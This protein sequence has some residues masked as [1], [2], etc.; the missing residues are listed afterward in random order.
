MKVLIIE[1]DPSMRDGLKSILEKESF[2]VECADNGNQGSYLA[3]SKNYDLILLDALLPGKHGSTVCK[4]IKQSG[5][6]TPIMV[7]S[8]CNEIDEKLKLFDLGVD[9]YLTKPYAPQELLA[10][11]TALNKRIGTPSSK[12]LTAGTL[13]VHL[14]T[15]QVFKNTKEISITCKEFSILELLLKNKNRVV[16]KGILFNELWS[17]R[18]LSESKTIETHILNLRKK[19]G[20]LGKQIIITVSGR[21]YKIVDK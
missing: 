4:E 13:T 21:G 16:S 1:D 5:K 17:G 2:I 6:Q 19:L 11:I 3:R 20:S 12:V 9:D 15:Q 14:D 7:L 18:S 10:R 8:V